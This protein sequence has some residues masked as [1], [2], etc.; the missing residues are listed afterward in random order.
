MTTTT[1]PPGRTDQTAA[2]SRQLALALLA[3]RFVQG[4]I[5]WGG[6]SR[7][8]IYAPAKL[9]P[10]AHSWMANKFQ[11]AMPGAILGMDHVVDFLLHHFALLYT[12]VIVF[13]AAELVFG[14]FLLFGFMTRLSALVTV[15]LS[16]VLML[17]FGWQGATCI[18]EW[19]MASAN[20]A[21]GIALF[22]AGAGAYS[23]DSWLQRRRPQLADRPWFQWLGS[24]DWPALRLKRWSLI[25]VWTTALF[26]VLTYNYYRG[27]VLTPFHGGPVSAAAHH[28]SLSGGRLDP[29]GAVRFTAYL[30]GGTPAAPANVVRADLSGPD[31]KPVEHWDSAALAAL[32][33]RAFVNDYAYNRFGPGYAGITARMGAR[34]LIALPPSQPG[35]RLSAGRY[36]LVLHSVDGRPFT[37]FLERDGQAAA[38]P[39]GSGIGP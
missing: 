34:A 33:Q 21:M 5:Y 29:D 19:T 14:L 27:S 32:P 3:V 18:D 12:G 35:L 20:F 23:I 30:D 26:V 15:G 8:F 2:A 16:F 24:G 1:L 4:W 9:D 11:S 7:R 36:E 31:G 13:S 22:L 37:L 10:H 28:I 38:V 25:G 39:A 17:L 6:G